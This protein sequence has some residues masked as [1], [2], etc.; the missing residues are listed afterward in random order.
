M[1]TEVLTIEMSHPFVFLPMHYLRP[2]GKS[3]QKLLSE[4]EYGEEHL[5]FVFGKQKINK[6]YEQEVIMH[7]IMSPNQ[8][9]FSHD[10]TKCTTL[11]CLCTV[12]PA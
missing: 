12:E 7:C 8:T 9:G 3:D 5:L 2:L 4:G 1:E 10:H 11:S 6:T